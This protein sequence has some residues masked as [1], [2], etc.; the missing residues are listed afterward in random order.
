MKLIELNLEKICELCRKYKVKTLSV[1]GSILTERFN[2]ESDV[3]F[4]ATFYPEEDPLVRG[5]N[6]LN[7]YMDLGDLM[8]RRID[9]VDESNLRNPYFIEELEETKQLIYGKVS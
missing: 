3:D 8:G 9:L 1:F 2:D 5:E 4:S 6:F 7:L